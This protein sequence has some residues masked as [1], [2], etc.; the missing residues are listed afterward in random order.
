MKTRLH[1][2]LIIRIL[3]LNQKK[4]ATNRALNE[5]PHHVCLNFDGFNERCNSKCK[6]K[7]LNP[8]VHGHLICQPPDEPMPPDG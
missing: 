8:L 6:E 2:S 1:K 5:E 7:E 4:K 3:P